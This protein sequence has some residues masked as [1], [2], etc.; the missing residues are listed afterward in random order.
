MKLLLIAQSL[1]YRGVERYVYILAKGLVKKGHTALILTGRIEKDALKIDPKVKLISPPIFINS[2]IQ[3]NFIYF[4]FSFPIILAL[5][6]KNSKEIGIIESEGGLAL[7]ASILVGK[8]RGIKVVWSVH[9]CKEKSR[10]E[11][12]R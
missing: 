8:L 10:S 3:N 4:I 1:S 5:L 11:S 2:L 6:L 7:W 9:I 12:F